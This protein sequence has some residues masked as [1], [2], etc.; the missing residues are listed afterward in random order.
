MEVFKPAWKNPSWYSAFCTHSV[1]IYF[2]KLQPDNPVTA[3]DY[4]GTSVFVKCTRVGPESV[5]LRVCFE[6]WSDSSAAI[7]STEREHQATA[8]RATDA[9]ALNTVVV[10]WALNEQDMT[11]LSTSGP[12]VERTT[13]ADWEYIASVPEDDPVVYFGIYTPE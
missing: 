1:D 2:L 5:K 6:S 8:V 9:E 13:W 10:L 7:G 11:N 3:F 4:H 12:T